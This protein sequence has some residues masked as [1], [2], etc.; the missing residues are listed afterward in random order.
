MPAK[1]SHNTG[2]VFAVFILLTFALHLSCASHYGRG[3]LARNSFTDPVSPTAININKADE[4]ELQTIPGIGPALA[5]KIIE[6]R[7]RH[8]PF[9]RPEEILIVEGISEKRFRELRSFIST[10]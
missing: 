3:G 10:E 7:D 1:Y 4:R 8:G 9:R 2:T 5:R 6:H